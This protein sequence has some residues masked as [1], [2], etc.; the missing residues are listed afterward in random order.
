MV[1]FW[2]QDARQISV[3]N[4][5]FCIIIASSPVF[6]LGEGGWRQG[7]KSDGGLKKHIFF[8]GACG[9]QNPGGAA[10]DWQGAG[11]RGL[12]GWDIPAGTPC[13]L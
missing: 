5:V 7:Q 3:C 2:I 4:Y 13:S 11:I 12:G 10:R 1:M 9:L 6:S 8:S